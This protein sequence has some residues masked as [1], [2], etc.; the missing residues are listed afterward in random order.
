MLQ[1]HRLV[2]FL[3][4]LHRICVEDRFCGEVTF[5]ILNSLPKQNERYFCSSV[6]YKSAN[7]F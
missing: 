4:A 3:E 7:G 5:S 2:V 1:E 6:V